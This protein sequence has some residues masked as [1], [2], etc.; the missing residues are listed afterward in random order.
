M[1]KLLAL[2]Y[3][4]IAFTTGTAVAQTMNAPA[5]VCISPDATNKRWASMSLSIGDMQ[6][7]NWSISVGGVPSV[8]G[9]DYNVLYGVVGSYST[10]GAPNSVGNRSITVEF[11]KP[12]TYRIR[13]VIT[14]ANGTTSTVNKNVVAA[15]CPMTICKGQNTTMAGFTEDFGQTTTRIPLDPARGTIEYIYQ[16]TGNL[17]DE[18]YTIANQLQQRPEWDASIDHTGNTN[19]AMLVANS[20][21][22]PKLFY[23]RRVN[24]LCTGAVYNFTAW[25]RNADGKGVMEGACAGGMIYAGVTFE[26]VNA[27]TNAVLQTFNTY[28][29]SAPLQANPINRGWQQYGGSFKTPPGVSSV[30]VRIRNNNPGGCGND[31]AIDDIAF[32]Y[33]APY[34]YSFFDGQTDQLGGEYTMC[35]GAATNLT[36]VY[37]PADYF[38]S[39]QYFWQYSDDNLTWTTISGDGDGVTGSATGILHFAEDALLLQGSPTVITQRWFRLMIY[40]AGNTSSCAQPSVPIK[41]ILLPNPKISVA[42][43]QICIGGSATLT[44]CCGYDT[45]TWDDPA[46][47]ES[48]NITVAPTTTTVYTVIGRKDY[49]S[50]RTCYRQADAPVIVDDMPVPN[51]TMTTPA[52]ICLGQ[53]VDISIDPINA[54]YDILWTPNGETTTSIHDVPTTPG[55]IAYGVTITNGTCSVTDS[56]TVTVRDLPDVTIG[57]IPASCRTSGSFTIPYTGATNNPS[58][59]DVVAAGANPMP[60]FTAVMNQAMPASPITVTYPVGTAPG[61]YTFNLVL[62]NTTLSCDRTKPFSVVVQAPSTPPTGILADKTQLCVSGTVT[63]TVQGGALGT[64]AVWRWYAGACGGA[65]LG[66]GPSITTGTISTT[67]TFYVRAESAGACGS[68]TCASA[69]VTVLAQPVTAAAGPDQE[70]CEVP[71]FLMAANPATPATA[72][73]TWSVI[74]ASVP[75]AN[76]VIASPT[77]QSSNVTVPNG[78]TATLAWTISNGVCPSTSDQVVL[79]NYSKPTVANAGPKQ[80]LCNATSFTLAA[81][82][83][84]IGTGTWTKVYGAA[85]TITNPN[86]PTTTVTG[87]TPGDSIILRWTIANG[88]CT[89]STSDVTLVTYKTPTVAVAGPDQKLC[90]V[91]SFTLAANTPAAGAGYG[92]WTTIS[93]GKAPVGLTTPNTTITVV[94]GDSIVL[95]WTIANGTCPPS[96]DDITLVSYKTPTVAAAGPDQ[97]LCNVT[98]FTLAANT[99]AAGAGYGYWT[100]ISGGKAPANLTSPTSTITVVPG[101]SIVLRWTIANGTCPPSTDDIT[102]V[103][104]KTPT[105][106]AAG[107]DQKLCNVT[108]FTLAANAPAAG[109]GYG[110]WTTISGGKAPANLTSPT[111][112][113][114]VVPGDSIVLRWTI[115]NGTCPPSTDDIT[116][117]SYKTPTIA[118]AG[119]DQK[120]CNVTSFTLAAN[121]PAAGAGYGYWTTISGG[122]A[123]AN[124]T[125][126]TSTITVVPG[127]SIVLRWTIANGTCPPST[128]DITLVSYKTPTVAAAGPD[129]KLCNVTSFT[130]AA[131]APAAGAGYGYWTTISGGKAPANLTS[132]TSTITVVPGDSIVLRWTIANGT[133]PPS[134]DD[135]T[136]VSYK[137]PTVAAAGP[138]QKLCNVTSFTLAANTP[139]A[140]AGY[141]YWTTISG[142]K[143]P[144]NLTSPTSTITVVPGDSIVLRWTIANGTCPPSTDDITLVSYKTPTVAAAGPD[145]KLCNVTSFTLA[146]NPPAAGAGYGYWTTISGGKAPAN[147]TSPTSTITVVPGDSIVLRWTIA[148]GTCPPSTND[149]TL[150]SYKTPTVADAGPDQKDC[151]VTSFTLAANTP[152]AGAGYGYWT[153]IYGSKAP[154]N[155]TSPTSTITVAPGDSIILRWT[156]ANGT[157]PPSTSDVTLVSYRTPTT[158]AAGPDQKLCNVTS[159]T[160]AANTP[161]AGAGYGYWTTI[162]GAKAPTNL[163]SP[164]STIA[165]V[166]GDSI[167]LRWTIA[168]GNCPPSTDDITLVSYRTPTVAAAGPDQKDCNVTSFTLAANTPTIGYGYW[169]TVYGGKAPAN[170]TSPTSTITVAPGDSI[171]LRWNIANGT[172]PPSTSDVTLVSYETPTVAAAG[173]DQKDCNVTSFTLAANTPT[174]GYGY[175]STVYGGKAPANLTDPNS[176]ITVA[177]GDSI[178]LRWN[179]ANGNCP[180]STN[181]VTLVSYKTPTVAAAGPDQK[182]CNVTSFTLAANTPAAG[183]GHGYWTTIYGGK[184]PTNLT[185]PTSA[186][187]VVPGDSI[188]LRWTIANG[189]CPPSTSDVT[190]VSYITP[191]VA[192]AGPNQKDCNVTSFTLAANTPTIGYGYWTTVY[193]GKAP[194]NLTDPASTI[195]VAPGD[196]IILRW[197]IANGNCPPS[198]SDVTLVSYLM[199]TTA[200]AGPDQKL[201]YTTSFTMAANTPAVNAGTGRWSVVYG[202]ANIATPTSP[203]SSVTIAQGDSVILRWTITNGNCAISTDDVTLISYESATI[204]AAGPDQKLC[205][206]TSFTL[207]ANT[208]AIGTGAWSIVHGTPVIA[209]LLSPT[210][211]VTVAPGDSVVLR[212]TISNGVLCPSNSDD[213]ILVSY[214]QPTVAAA[215]ADQKLCN[216]TSFTLAANTPSVGTGKWSILYGTPVIASLTSATSTVTV[217]PG[218]SVVL[219]W[220][221]SNGTCPPSTS[222]VT[223]VSYKT[224]TVAAAGPN[225][226]LCN[227][228]SFTLAANT[229]AAGAGYGYWTTIYGGKAPANLTSPTSTITVVPG[230]SIILRWTIANG[231]CPPSTSDV[232]LVSYITPTVAAAGPDQKDC[233]VTSFTLAAN[234]P[235]AGAG[236]GYWTTIY[237][238]KAPANLTSPTSA[239]TVAPGDSIVL[240]WTIANGTCPPSTDDIILVS[241]RTPTTAAAGPN[242]KLCNVTSFTLAANTPAAGAGYGYWTTIYGGKA[243]ANLTSPT[244]TIAVVPGDSIILRWTIANG[245]CPP[246]TSDVTLVSYKTPTV[247]AA[248]PNQK[249][250]NVTSF[251][252]AANTPAAGAGYGYWT[253]IYGGKAPANL[254]SPTS[255]IA[256]APGDSIILRWTIANGNCPP[257]TSDV[258][259][260]S[261]AQ[262]TIA[263][264]GAD[265]KLCNVTS[266]T[267]AGNTPT[268]GKGVWT[269]IYGNPVIANPN[270]PTSTITVAAGDSVILRWTIS[271]GNCPPSTDDVTLVSYKTAAPAL[272]GPDQKMCNVTS[273]TLAA[274][275]PSVPTAKGRWSIIYGTPVIANLTSPTTT[276]T[277]VPGDSVILRWTITNGT[278]P[279]TSDDVVL[280][281][282]RQPTIAAAGADQK[283]C[284]VTSFTLAGNTPTVGTGRWTVIYGTATIAAPT[285]PTSTVTV[286][287]GDSV[288]LRWTISNGVCPATSDDVVLVNYRTPAMANA[289][290]DQDMCSN[291]TSFTMR[292]NAPGVTGAVGTWTIVSGTATI[293]DI[294]NPTTTV[295]VAVGNTVTLRWTITNGT[296]A[297]SNDDVVIANRNLITNNT[298]SADQTVCLTEIPAALTGTTPTGGNGTYTYQWQSSTTSA[299]AG[300]VSIPGATA[301][302]YAPGLLTQDTWY[303]RVVTSGFC[304]SVTSNAVKITVINKPPVVTFVPGPMT[305]DCRMG[306]DYTTLFGTPQFSHTPYTNMPLTVTFTDANSVNGCTQTFTRTWTATDRCGMTTTASQTITVVDRTA[307]VFTSQKPADVTVEC[308]KIPAAVNLNAVDDCFGN[309]SVTPVETRQD[310][311]GACVNNYKL[312]RTWTAVDGCNNR[313]TL[314]QTITVQDKTPP[315]FTG[316]APRDTIVNCNAVPPAAPLTAMDNCTPGVITVTATD[317]RKNIPGAKCTDNYQIVR[318]WIAR[319]ECG[320]M[321]TLVQNITVQDT[322]RPVFSMPQPANVTVDCDKVPSWPAITAT[323]NCTAN[324]PVMTSEQ[325][326]ATQPACAGNYRLVRTWKAT[327]NCGNTATMTQTITVQDTTR[328]VFTVRPPADTTVNC[329]AVPA[330]P[331]NVVATDA[332][333]TVKLSR[334]QVRENIPGACA[335]NY[336]LIRTWIAID[337]CGNQ[338]VWRQVI[339]VQDTTRPV[340]T[341]PP[342]DVVLNC[343]DAIPA[344]PVLTATDNCDPAFPKQAAMTEDPYVKDVCSGY[345]I[346][347]RWRVADACGNQ[348]TEVIQRIV[349]NACPKPVL[350][351]ALPV[352]CSDN[353]TFTIKTLNNVTNPTYILVGVVPANAVQVPWS[354][355]NGAFN[356]NNATQASFIVR[357]G[358]TGC[359]SDTVVYN[360]QYNTSPMVNLGRDTTICGGNSLILDAGAGNFAYTIRWS[361]GETTQRINIT[362]AGKYWVSVTNG[363]CTTTDTIQVTVIPMPLVDIPDASICRGQSVK[364]DAFVDGGTYLW[365]NGATSSS[366]LVSTQE[367]FWVQVVKSG[368]ITIDTVNVTVNPP[369]DITLNRDTT[370]CP[371]QSVMLTVNLNNGGNIRWVTGA[372]TNSIVVNEPG[373]YWVTVSRDNCMI[374][375]TVNVRLQPSI[376]VELG[377]NQEICPGSQITI[378][379]TTQDAI[380]YLWDDGDPNPVKNLFETGKYRLGVMDRFC[381]RVFYDSVY[382]R[383]ADM[384]RIDLGLDTVMCIGETLRLRAEGANIKS[385]LWSDGSTGPYLDVKAAG[386]YAVTVFND[387]GSATDQITV[388]YTQCDPKPTFPNAFSPNGDGKNDFFRPVV[389]GPMYEYE[390]RIFNRWGELIYLGYDSKKGWDGRYQG[391]PVT[392]GTYVW[393]LT[394]KKMPNGNPNIIKGEVTVIR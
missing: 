22:D 365:S 319:D 78:A 312:I 105:V 34:I 82:T 260:V 77:N 217:V 8:A 74:S 108:S 348:A 391:Q 75:V 56:R 101:D 69:T 290:P 47:T 211:T 181:D 206:V 103:S 67:T 388:D 270:S 127:D 213:V 263:A 356:L 340:I 249:L 182:Q 57:S 342:A 114:T 194:A 83:A 68:S 36:S 278:C 332:C 218:D 160:L 116:L 215:G 343:G 64:G 151:N 239:I 282:Y 129:Q 275:T 314:T 23:S 7:T 173:P 364:L 279:A 117:V 244:S 372:T 354:Q 88:P 389:R 201:C 190:L 299:T 228:T 316:T 259:L 291:T 345:T 373:Q 375:D 62:H 120:L 327:D 93:G 261:Y 174:I 380:S 292:A 191:T 31:I 324:V 226:K 295:T 165:V 196:S 175:W 140:G 347:R 5:T 33:C 320:N 135:I 245:T 346:I 150:V 48:D 139:A 27:T 184:A 183:A 44:A 97:K 15:S 11:L 281:S 252:L 18:Y 386:T 24:G 152:A 85:G 159:F 276:I 247:A 96:T 326:F 146:A 212:W 193:G 334:T 288:I 200:A 269:K 41:V 308:D 266:F 350:D 219:R 283:L 107:P 367:Q 318:T 119:P 32:S 382:L 123:P 51:L 186:I 255:T 344:A 311:P 124:L 50:G 14:N 313:V 94:P 339:T 112:T 13:A 359:I 257:S 167:I 207:A 243:P 280:V 376:K 153:T 163:T 384:P 79:T 377:P 73:G 102:L 202:T 98:S 310:I 331:N 203:A 374:K 300:F 86:S 43:A 264:A 381:N 338:A 179:I 262:P 128:D 273:F 162:Y 286:A 358:V 268:V 305:V 76:I 1:K 10:G 349:V 45:Y 241:Y 90:N 387:C 4:L 65:L 92:Y 353:P 238:G 131:N 370:I 130:L 29:V 229:P 132:P 233:N 274:N 156:I 237:G 177:P 2:L 170:L 328:P 366:I 235:A 52:T 265:Q 336:R 100:T 38:T 199:P 53:A 236:Y 301:A 205:N 208:P 149:V 221:I 258:T 271:N 227:V 195:T 95:R 330:P 113:I 256:V 136:L 242:Q 3:L 306:M 317:V 12:A 71:T 37:A 232:T 277:V 253:T 35:A 178:I 9:V 81:N 171:V 17:N 145:Q 272:A 214:E 59:Y 176:T 189:N 106:A 19:G 329:D 210:S 54:G 144:A 121:A 158:A 337:Q 392:I 87:L 296:C 125:S 99:P 66:T 378:D 362:N 133:C 16:P 222:D 166:P 30:I 169:S 180:P 335:S 147:L 60:G 84:T 298:I 352:N 109:A 148:N 204:A 234:T 379:G 383:V 28:D 390:L 307:P 368:C 168:N 394:Y 363:I 351:P 197:N 91:T 240:R 251:T 49:G 164:T 89:P 369:P 220:T 61:T 385:V 192:A 187:T 289:G 154:T 284:N 25:F 26:I 122:K 126:P 63:L 40:E 285:S 188:I 104:Y 6:G 20:A 172:C 198:T 115:A 138:D 225:Q 321:A 209:D 361:T 231:V 325:K 58:R 250:C 355:Q 322:T 72:T 111:S 224:P 357:D 333:G 323:D 143:A 248:G 39:P 42:G 297:M 303:R 246:S 230:D 46:A 304:A 141:G 157:C 21:Y 55:S 371:D 254:T 223:L 70:H 110:Y 341:A 137:T 134:T 294:H 267:L 161:A 302:T 393:W 309:M 287:A 315:V 118:A 216:V 185:S 360:L 80:R 155:L 142:G 293:A